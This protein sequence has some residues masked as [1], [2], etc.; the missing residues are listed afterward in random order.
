MYG[1]QF[2]S[3]FILIKTALKLVSILN[4]DKLSIS[5]FMEPCYFI[6]TN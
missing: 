6:F 2:T 3:S 4:V 1:E 5:S